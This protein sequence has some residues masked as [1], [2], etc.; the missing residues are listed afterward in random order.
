MG[1]HFEP[2][3][4]ALN[5]VFHV[6]LLGFISKVRPHFVT[7][8]SQLFVSQPFLAD[9]DNSLRY[10]Q[11]IFLQ[12]IFRMLFALPFKRQ[13]RGPMSP[14]SLLLGSVF[15]QFLVVHPLI[16]V[17]QIRYDPAA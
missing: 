2:K 11:E 10:Q 8:P 5:T 16:K 9:C 17:V 12:F 15:G 14:L 4:E 6:I 13:F 7:H 1:V 3:H